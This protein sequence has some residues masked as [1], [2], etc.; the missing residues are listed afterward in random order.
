M[1]IDIIYRQDMGRSCLVGYPSVKTMLMTGKAKCLYTMMKFE[2]GLLIREFCM[3]VQLVVHYWN[4]G[5]RIQTIKIP[6]PAG[7]KT[8]I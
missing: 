8:A 2:A 5:M 3:L 1:D 6:R 7:W 4:D